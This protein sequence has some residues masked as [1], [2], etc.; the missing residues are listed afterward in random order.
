MEINKYQKIEV[1]TK[2]TE[3]QKIDE[4]IMILAELKG[5]MEQ[6][7]CTGIHA[8]FYDYNISDIKDI[9]DFLENFKT[10]EEIY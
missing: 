10:I 1:R 4:V 2:Y 3:D 6:N 5:V 8:E 9:I 7:N